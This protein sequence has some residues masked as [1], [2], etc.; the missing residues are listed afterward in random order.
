VQ[1]YPNP[2]AAVNATAAFP[3]L[4]PFLHL[5]PDQAIRSSTTAS[6]LPRAPFD[7]KIGYKTSL[8]HRRAL[9]NNHNDQ[10]E[11]PSDNPETPSPPG[12]WMAFVESWPYCYYYEPD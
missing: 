4:D 5:A 1:E 9:E 7:G 12:T 2:P 3:G 6:T 10:L 11:T 8:L